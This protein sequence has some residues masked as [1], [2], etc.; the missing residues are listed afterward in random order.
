MYIMIKKNINDI[1]T[2]R[3]CYNRNFC[4]VLVTSG[5]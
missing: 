5:N 2:Y 3:W 4:N 1:A